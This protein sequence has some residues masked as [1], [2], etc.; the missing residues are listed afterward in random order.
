MAVHNAYEN[1]YEYEMA[2]LGIDPSARWKS[3]HQYH[4]GIL[5]LEGFDRKPS[6]RGKRRTSPPGGSSTDPKAALDWRV[7]YLTNGLSNSNV[8]IREKIVGVLI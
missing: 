3:G 8:R 7:R 4:A 1:G 5:G 2:E 6:N